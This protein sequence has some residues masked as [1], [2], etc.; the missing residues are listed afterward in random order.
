MCII[1]GENKIAQSGCTHLYIIESY[2]SL[3]FIQICIRLFEIFVS[4]CLSY[5]FKVKNIYIL[6]INKKYFISSIS[7]FITALIKLSMTSSLVNFPSVMS[8]KK[9]KNFC[10]NLHFF[11]KQCSTN[12]PDSSSHS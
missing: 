10:M 5:E 8:K 6:N 7:L 3:C 4:F 1:D 2:L 9:I 11:I 12:M